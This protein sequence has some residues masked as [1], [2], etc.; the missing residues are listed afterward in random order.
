M[1]IFRVV[2]LMELNFLILAP[3]IPVFRRMIKGKGFYIDIAE[4]AMLFS[5]C[6]A[7]LILAVTIYL[8]LDMVGG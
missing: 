4:S 3:I 2:L 1:Q 6:S 5:V 8:V 7:I